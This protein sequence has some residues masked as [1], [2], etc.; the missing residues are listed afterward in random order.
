[1]AEDVASA[2]AA[3][4][5]DEDSAADTTSEQTASEQTEEAASETPEFSYE[6]D[7]E[8]IEDL[9]AEPDPDEYELEDDDDPEPVVVQQTDEYA[10]PEVARLQARLAKAEKQLKFQTDLRAKDNLKGWRAEAARRFPLADVD[11]IDASSRRAVL[12]KAEEQHTRYYKKV[13]PV[14]NQ[15]EALKAQVLTEAKQE[16][17]EQAAAAYGRPTTAPQIAQVTTAEE[18]IDPRK[19]KTLHDLTLARIRS[20]QLKGVVGDMVE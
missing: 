6:A 19:F 7:T 2:V 13:E 15:I 1:M 8:G 12:R 20:G 18:Q 4:L 3:A 10:D 17:R 9:L 14:L 16:G 5:I 11:E